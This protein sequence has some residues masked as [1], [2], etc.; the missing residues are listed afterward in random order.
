MSIFYLSISQNNLELPAEQSDSDYHLSHKND[1]SNASTSL[2]HTNITEN[3]SRVLKTSI[4]VL[5]IVNLF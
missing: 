1:I 5:M 2:H 3:M 4:S